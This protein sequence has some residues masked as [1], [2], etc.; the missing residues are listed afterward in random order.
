MIELAK[1]LK[2][3]ARGELEITDAI[4]WL[5]DQKVDIISCSLGALAIPQDGKDP[6]ALAAQAAVDAGIT[7]INSE[8]NEGPGQGTMGSSPDAP[9]LLA[10][11]AVPSS[12]R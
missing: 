2:P 9:G 7:F 6:G 3:S 11:G 10:V 1:S 8:G 4:Q 5:V 12:S